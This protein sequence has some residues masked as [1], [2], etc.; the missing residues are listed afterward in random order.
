MDWKSYWP[1]ASTANGVAS[2]VTAVPMP[3]RATGTELPLSTGR[4][5]VGAERVELMR[6]M[7]PG[8]AGAHRRRMARRAR[9]ERRV[10]CFIVTDTSFSRNC[11]RQLIHTLW[12]EG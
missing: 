9:G 10:G 8:A 4:F 11:A 1:G 7:L 6:M 3:E 5:Q 12:E 2:K